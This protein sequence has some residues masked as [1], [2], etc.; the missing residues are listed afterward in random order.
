MTSPGINSYH[1]LCAENSWIRWLN[2]PIHINESDRMDDPITIC[3]YLETIFRNL[4][5]IFRHRRIHFSCKDNLILNDVM[6]YYFE[7]WRVHRLNVSIKYDY[8]LTKFGKSQRKKGLLPTAEMMECL[9]RKFTNSFWIKFQNEFGMSY[10]IFDP[11]LSEF[12]NIFWN[13]IRY[14]LYQYIDIQYLESESNSFERFEYSSDSYKTSENNESNDYI[15]AG[16]KITKKNLSDDPYVIDQFLAK[17]SGV[18]W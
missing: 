5:D 16:L 13:N 14:F 10:G 18:N 11:E 6:N 3:Q 15:H 1:Q 8:H 2:S 17:E 7:L 4:F 12:G 9:D